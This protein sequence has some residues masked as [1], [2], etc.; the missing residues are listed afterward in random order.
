MNHARANTVPFRLIE[1]GLVNVTRSEMVRQMVADLIRFDAAGNEAD[2]IRSLY[3]TNRYSMT[4]IVMNI[5]NVRQ[6]AF[7]RT[8]DVVAREMVES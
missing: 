3:G 5:D 8:V 1:G 4:D 7:Q 2:A 6:A